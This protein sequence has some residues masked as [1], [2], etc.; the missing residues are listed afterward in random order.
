MLMRPN[1]PGVS[2]RSVLSKIGPAPH[3][4]ARLI[5]PVVD[6]VD[7]ALVDRLGLVG[8]RHR[9]VAGAG[10]R[11]VGSGQQVAQIGEER[12]LVDVEIE[13]DR[14]QRHDRA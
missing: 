4:A 11:R 12:A 5:E 14:V 2:D 8:Q 6:E 13:L 9:H 7:L 1:S 3:R 10:L